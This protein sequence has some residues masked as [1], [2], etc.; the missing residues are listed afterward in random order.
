MASIATRPIVELVVLARTD[1]Q[2]EGGCKSFAGC[3]KLAHCGLKKEGK[4]QQ[5]SQV[6]YIEDKVL[7]MK[8]E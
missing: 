8:K 4:Q 7:T 5:K 6:K 2:G 3:V 1:N